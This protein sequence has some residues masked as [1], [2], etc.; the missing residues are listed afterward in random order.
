MDFYQY[1]SSYLY[2]LYIYNSATFCYKTFR[3]KKQLTLS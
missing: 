1:L 2:V 3:K